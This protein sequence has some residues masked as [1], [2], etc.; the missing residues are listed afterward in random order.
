MEYFHFGFFV[1]LGVC[2]IEN[3]GPKAR[4]FFPY[5]NASRGAVRDLKACARRQK[6]EVKMVNIKSNK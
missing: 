3:M 6:K 1:I 4:Y 5:F 2:L